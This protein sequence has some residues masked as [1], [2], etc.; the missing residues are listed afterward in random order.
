MSKAIMRK[1]IPKNKRY[2]RAVVQQFAGIEKRKALWNCLCD[3]GVQFVTTGISLR[4]GTTKSCGCLQRERAATANRIVKGQASFNALYYKYRKQAE[5]RK[6]PFEL[7]KATFAK[8]TKENCFYC[9]TKPK[10]KFQQKQ[11]YGAYTYN[12]IDRIDNNKGYTINNS[13]PSC[14][15]CNYAKR[16]LSQ[17]EFEK[18][19]RK[20]YLNLNQVPIRAIA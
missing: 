19:I 3:C 18:W 12:G 2:G 13:I 8:I 17:G 16:D 11:Y 6:I 15:Q 5:R 20:I 4:K 14:K 9:G 10:Q 7:D 1:I